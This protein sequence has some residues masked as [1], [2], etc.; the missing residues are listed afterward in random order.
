MT[1]RS[2]LSVHSMKHFM[3]NLR[4]DGLDMCCELFSWMAQA[5]LI[6]FIQQQLMLFE[7]ANSTDLELITR[8]MIA[9]INIP[10]FRTHLKFTHL[11]RLMS[12]IENRKSTV[13]AL[14]WF[15]KRTV[16]IINK[17]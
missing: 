6:K 5:W 14:W 16:N 9:M 8:R 7:T 17:A 11:T 1:R 3:T 13:E 4:V 12:G 15:T 10:R 2:F